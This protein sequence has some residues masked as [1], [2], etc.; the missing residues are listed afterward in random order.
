MFKNFVSDYFTTLRNIY[1]RK[2]SPF[3]SFYDFVLKLMYWTGAFPICLD[4]EKK[5]IAIHAH[6]FYNGFTLVSM[7]L[8]VTSIMSDTAYPDTYKN[9]IFLG[10][11]LVMSSG[12]S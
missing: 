4:V 10:D 7:L 8:Q 3:N 9:L 5:T 12:A 2:A 11:D 1:L 6:R